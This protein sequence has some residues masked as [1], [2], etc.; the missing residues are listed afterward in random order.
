MEVQINLRDHQIPMAQNIDSLYSNDKRFAGV[1][2]A[3]GGGKSFLAMDQIIKKANSYNEENGLGQPDIED[4][5]LSNLPMYYFSPTN[6]ILYQFQLH[7]AQNVIAPEYLIQ[8]IRENGEITESNAKDVISRII[9]K[10]NSRINIEALS[11]DEV[12]SSVTQDLID[13]GES[14][15][16]EDVV[17][18]AM[19][20]TLEKI[21]STQME[22]IAEKAFPGITFTTYSDLE[23]R[24]EKEIKEMDSRFIIF[25]EA[26]R[27]GAEKWWDKVQKLVQ[28]SKADVLAITATPERDVDEKDMMRDLALL[29]GT[30]FSV[31]E[32][33]EKKYLAGNMPLLKAIEQGHI[34]PPEVVHF[35]CTLDETPEYEKAFNEYIKAITK[36][37]KA[38]SGS[39]AYI[40]AQN[41]LSSAERNFLNMLKVIRKNPLIDYDETLTQQEKDSLK[42][43]DEANVE[44]SLREI[45]SSVRKAVNQG[46]K[47]GYTDA[48][49]IQIASEMLNSEEWQKLKAE[50]ISSIMSLEV[51]K[52]GISHSKAI[53]FIEPMDKGPKGETPEQKKER[54][55]GYIQGKIEEI[56][57]L[58]KSHIPDVSAVHSTAFTDKENQNILQRFMEASTKTG[59]MKIIAAVSKFN[60]G[61]H[62][63]GIKALLM[64]KPIA[65]NDKKE[66]EPRIILLQQIGRCLSANGKKERPVIFD[67]AGN[68]MRNHE[69]FKAE[70]GKECFSFLDLSEEEKKFLSYS[71]KISARA[72]TAERPDTE[73]LIKILDILRKNNIEISAD[74]IKEDS[75][76]Q[77][78]ID[79][80]QDDVLK[81]KVLDELFLENIELDSDGKFELGKSYRFTRDVLLGIADDKIALKKLKGTIKETISQ[82]LCKTQG[83]KKV[84]PEE[85]DENTTSMLI[86]LGI[87]DTKSKEGRESLQKRT[88]S[89]G[90]IVRGVLEN[91]FAFNIYTGT[92]FDGPETDE[93]RKDYYGC[94]P[95]GRDFAGF[96]RY[97]FNEQG[98]HRRTGKP[99]DERHFSPRISTGKDG[100]ETISWV[101]VDPDTGRESQTDPLGFNHE[102]INPRTGFDRQGYWH[103][104]KTNGEYSIIRSKLNP[105]GRD[106]HDFLFKGNDTYGE[107]TPGVVRTLNGLYSNG[108]TLTPKEHRVA[109]TKQIQAARYGNDERDIDGF[110]RRGFNNQG[111]HRDTSTRY[112]LAGRNVAKELHPDLQ[113][114]KSIIETLIKN[115]KA[116]ITIICRAAGISEKNESER[117]IDRVIDSALSMY[118][119]LPM[120]RVEH[121]KLIGDLR[122]NSKALDRIFELSATAGRQLDAANIDRSKMIQYTEKRINEIIARVSKNKEHY[123]QGEIPEL[124]EYNKKIND[125]PIGAIKYREQDDSDFIEL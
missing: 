100:E 71:G 106:V 101:Y 34:M 28:Y 66:N 59:P 39:N 85:I 46:I 75:S 63:D 60:E 116:S 44:K 61:F 93:Y 90:F 31:K 6:I 29:D 88:N 96:D 20:K 23:R 81:D 122:K 8:D 36:V 7:M 45:L 121:E 43:E 109:T 9:G 12:I 56:K 25:D 103:E 52:R 49:L 86:K 89:L 102:G 18:G 105:E 125:E 35:N 16:I 113:K 14:Y 53:T 82:D 74:T 69:K 114:T 54:A 107:I 32:V 73:K 112:D 78:F 26:H 10:M 37:Y 99:Y 72:K 50:R 124:E 83:K 24:T 119:T 4:G 33:R 108:T 41:N 91:T 123:N 1:I 21:E 64:S 17:K 22:R 104:Q 48:K 94:L 110:D 77:S 95:N 19:N 65:Q 79:E 70:A 115:P 87:I 97:G 58:F 111:I 40:N 30:G 80:M 13:S 5:V 68:F 51:E 67:I 84:T 118:R 3:T 117:E 38:R 98:I 15:Q 47:E 11:I 42:Q 92:R 62:P 27:T 57:G 120:V 55:K 2:L 76:L